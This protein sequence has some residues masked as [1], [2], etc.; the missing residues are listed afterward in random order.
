V[1]VAALEVLR[2][3]RPHWPTRTVAL[4]TT[5]AVVALIAVVI[6]NYTVRLYTDYSQQ[7]FGHHYLAQGISHRGRSWYTASAS[8]AVATRQ[9]LDEVERIS[10]PGVRLFVGT[11]D[12]RK[13]PYSDAFFYYLLPQ[14]TP[15]TYYI[16][17]TGVAAAKD[18]GLAGEVH[19]ADL[20]ILSTA[21][22]NWDE[23][24]NSR[25]VGPDT[26]NQVVRTQFCLVGSYGPHY[27]LYRHCHR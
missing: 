1:P 10:K 23:P 3:H 8:D 17:I 6:P 18:S 19:R 12:L 26:P 25:Q 4:A 21:W 20:L 22:S 2:V 11:Q 15:G 13:T 9:L 5:T 16:D 27:K 7:T 24:N 14:L